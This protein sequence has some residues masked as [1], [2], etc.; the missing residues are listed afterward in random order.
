MYMSYLISVLRTVVLRNSA[1]P[2]RT[3]SMPMV[4]LS[5]PP[6]DDAKRTLALPC[7][8]VVHGYCTAT[9]VAA[10]RGARSAYQIMLLIKNVT[11]C[12]HYQLMFAVVPP[13]SRSSSQ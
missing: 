12:S 3:E 1:A 10:F 9:T 11:A 8:L 6:S 2:V 7:T 4:R 13:V 5:S